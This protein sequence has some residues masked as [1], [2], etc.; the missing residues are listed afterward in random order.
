MTSGQIVVYKR[1]WSESWKGRGTQTVETAPAPLS[2]Y[3]Q[4]PEGK[5]QESRLHHVD[6]YS[7]FEVKICPTN[8]GKLTML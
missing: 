3:S 4:I 5:N 1:S 2:L 8:G 6:A 7:L